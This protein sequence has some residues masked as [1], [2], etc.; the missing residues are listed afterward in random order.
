MSSVLKAIGAALLALYA[1]SWLN[2]LDFRLCVG[3][4]G[5]CGDMSMPAKPIRKELRT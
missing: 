4:P 5:A 2:V 1:L 3:V